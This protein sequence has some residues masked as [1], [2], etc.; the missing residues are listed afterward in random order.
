MKLK[1]T[2]LI[3]SLLFFS[4]GRLNAF[5]NKQLAVLSNGQ[6]SKS[7]KLYN[8]LQS[9]YFSIKDIASYYGAMLEWYPISGKVALIR[10]N[11]R[12]EVYI[13]STR[14]HFNGKKKR[15]NN[16]IEMEND[17]VYLPAEILISDYFSDFS[18][19]KSVIDREKGTLEIIRRPSLFLRKF[20]IDGNTAHIFFE[21]PPHTECK[22]FIKKASIDLIFS[23]GAAKPE[24]TQYNNGMIDEISLA[25]YKNKATALI[26]L[27]SGAEKMK[28]AASQKGNGVE[29]IITS[30]EL[31]P[32]KRSSML[33]GSED[34]DENAE[35]EPLATLPAVSNLTGHKTIIILDAGHG[36]EDPGAIG[37]DK[38]PEKEI[39]LSIVKKLK[40]CLDEDGEFETYLTRPNDTFIPLAERTNLA[41]EKKADLF[42]SIH[43]N[44]S[45]DKD[46][47]GFEIYFLSENA[48]DS[49]AQATAMFENSVVH[50]EK[51]PTEKQSKLQNLLWS[52]A[53]NEFINESSELSSLIAE[54]VAEKGK[55][56]NRGVKQA[57]F[58][59]LRGAGMPAVLIET[60]FISNRKD[61]AKLEKGKFQKQL[62]RLIYYGIKKYEARKY[63]EIKRE[64]KS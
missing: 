22:Y 34:I 2:F 61:E 50:F 30:S 46:S 27:S 62:A 41:N 18:E 1:Y 35:L 53:V 28:I 6:A 7:I 33:K 16:P 44:A 59:V 60:A 36:G 37:P 20:Y 63:D 13:K 48:T 54:Q 57:G 25:N 40:D 29:F 58:F 23:K 11:E 17:E 26:S 47:K 19:T 12:I 10:N 8:T 21:T 38:V 9:D 31:N 45:L 5:E 55:V 43:C 49:E 3:L 32:I 42:I 24:K 15:L 52:M 14:L 64:N 39:T 51:K 56:E 4:F